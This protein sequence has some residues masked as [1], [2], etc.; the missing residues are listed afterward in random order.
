M[1]NLKPDSNLV[2]DLSVV[3]FPHPGPLVACEGT[4]SKGQHIHHG[5][6]GEEQNQTASHIR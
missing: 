5:A 2:V 3:S 6:C 4:A 1:H